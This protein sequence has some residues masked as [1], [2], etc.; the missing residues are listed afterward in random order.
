MNKRM[1]N[2][3]SVLAALFCFAA[4]VPA[5]I[6]LGPGQPYSNLQA[7][8]S[9]IQPGDTVFL[10]AGKYSGYQGATFKGDKDHWITIMPYRN[11]SAII[12]GQW[13]LS[14]IAFV[15]FSRLTFRGNDP[16]CAPASYPFHLMIIDNS[17]DCATQS[18]H[19][20]VENCMFL[21]VYNPTPSSNANLKF[22]GVDSF[23][24]RNC[25][26]K[27]SIGGADGLSLNTCRH[28]T[29]ENCKFQ[30]IIGG[31]GTHCKG[32]ATDITYR[33]NIFVNCG[34]RSIVVGGNTGAQF[35]CPGVGYEAMD[36]RVYSN[37]TVGSQ[38]G[39]ALASCNNTEVVNNTFYKPTEFGFRILNESPS[40]PFANN[41]IYN[42]II[43]TSSAVNCYLNGSSDVDYSTFH[44]SNN[45][46][47]VYNN[48]NWKGPGWGEYGGATDPHQIVAD[49]MFADT[50]SASLDLSLK[51]QSPAIGAGK[52]DRKSVV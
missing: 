34:S 8:A 31:Y 43:Y 45:L 40:M 32:G 47:W 17:G 12:I 21:D 23:E 46:F 22:A 6:H 13:Q 26:I 52:K 39:I 41:V 7:A 35:F 25:T 2:K 4:Q 33:N 14:S 37:M 51:S 5:Q 3:Y 44:F 20:T 49:P 11:D 18:Q 30:D 19:V 29:V 50:D 16:S 36:I 48:P 28:G 9:A 24:I 10:H 38:A 42:N 15:K 1:L 27:G